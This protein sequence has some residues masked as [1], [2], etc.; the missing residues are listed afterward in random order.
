MA[1]TSLL[2]LTTPCALRIALSAE[3]EDDKPIDVTELTTKGLFNEIA[4]DQDGRRI[5]QGLTAHAKTQLKWEDKKLHVLCPT[6]WDDAT[7]MSLS[8]AQTV[9]SFIG[10]GDFRQDPRSPQAWLGAYMFLLLTLATFG[11]KCDC[12]KLVSILDSPMWQYSLVCPSYA[13]SPPRTTRPR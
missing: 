9:Q 7:D 2:R 11:C 5:V 12:P 10:G 6:T 3:E 1:S 8:A 13:S 4:K